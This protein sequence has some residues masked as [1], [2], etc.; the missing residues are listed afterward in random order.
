M[1]IE[2]FTKSEIKGLNFLAKHSRIKKSNLIFSKDKEIGFLS[3][4][5]SKLIVK[6]YYFSRIIHLIY[7]NYK[8]YFYNKICNFN[9]VFYP[10]D[11]FIDWNKI[12]GSKGFFQIQFVIPKNKFKKILGEIS[13]FFEKKKLFSPFVVIKRIDEK[14]KYLNYYG[15]GYSISFDFKINKRF[16]NIKFFFNSIIHKYKL[17]VN[18]SKD[19]VVDKINASNYPEFKLFKKEILLLNSK[20]KINSLFSKRLKI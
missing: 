9:E 8:K 10:Q 20:K 12:Y 18:F 17:K 16:E 19:L 15:S 5:I 7:K 2:N 4:F 11:Q 3:L 6:N 1:W 14:G 13:T